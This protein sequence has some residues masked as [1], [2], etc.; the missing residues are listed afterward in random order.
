LLWWDIGN[1]KIADP[2]VADQ[3]VDNWG[4]IWQGEAAFRL[5]RG[6]AERIKNLELGRAE[7]QA[8]MLIETME[9]FQ[10]MEISELGAGNVR[11]MMLARLAQLLD[12][13]ADQGFLPPGSR[14]EILPPI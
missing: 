8:K 12:G 5:A 1:F 13:L 2:R 7:A 14:D 4:T 6:E 9:A 10:N 3:L 11:N